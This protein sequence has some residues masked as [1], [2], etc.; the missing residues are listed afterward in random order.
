MYENT[1]I[2]ICVVFFFYL[3]GK[4]KRSSEKL[5]CFQDK[6]IRTELVRLMEA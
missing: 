2:N 3:K 6:V 4:L 1:S 5:G